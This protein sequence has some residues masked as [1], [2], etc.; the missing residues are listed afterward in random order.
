MKFGP[1][2]SLISLSPVI[3]FI[4]RQPK[5][6]LQIQRP[7]RGKVNLSAGGTAFIYQILTSVDI[8]FCCLKAV[9]ALK[10]FEYNFYG[11]RPITYIGIQ[12]K[13]KE[14]TRTFMIISN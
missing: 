2:P 14:L 4:W 8:R 1:I 12:I 11:C 6:P 10:Y 5:G 9:P 13:K 3:F 7:S